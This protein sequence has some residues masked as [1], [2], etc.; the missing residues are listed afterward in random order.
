ME[1]KVTLACGDGGELAHKLIQQV[2]VSA[3]QNQD[4]SRFDSAF[5]SLESGKIA[6][7]TDSFVVNP[8]FFPGGNIG[9]IAVAG[10]VND[11]SVAGSIPL[12]LTA[13]FIIEEGFPLEDLR[14]IVRSLAEEASAAGVRI[15]AGDTKV[16]EKGGADGLYINTTGIGVQRA[17]H[18]IRPGEMQEGDD[19]IISG[20]VG[21]HGIAILAARGELGLMTDLQ[22]DCTPLNHMI[23]KVLESGA[24]VRMMRDPT[25][26]GV[27]TTLVEIAE[28]FGAAIEISETALPIRNEVMGACDILGFD[29]LY[30]ANEGKV[31][32][33]VARN[34]RQRVLD[35]LR[36]FPEG[37]NA[38]V[39][40]HITGMGEGRLL[41][42]TPLGSRRRLR[43]L[44]GMMLPRIC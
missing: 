34:D 37:R 13:G 16:V 5:L 9:K 39:I 36:A 26:G 7:T 2:F 32:L 25:R 30:L 14:K 17:E 23:D 20:T 11:L 10:T 19:V 15:V 24:H 40:G 18:A 21:D 8:L 3:F 31:I 43:R 4:A 29:P 41:L 44:S 22:S 27:A 33:I 28:D 1:R 35:V 6:V 12:Y 42:E 38:A